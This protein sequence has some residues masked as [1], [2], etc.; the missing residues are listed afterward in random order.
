[1]T[2]E[3]KIKNKSGPWSKD[4]KQYISENALKQSPDEIAKKLRRNPNAVEKYM[5]SQGL[6]AESGKIPSKI[7]VEHDIKDTPHWTE[8]KK[9]FSKDELE[10]VVYHWNNTI[11]QF[12]NDIF[13]TEELQIIDMIK[14]QVMMDRL[15]IKEQE[16]K[17]N[18]EFL[19]KKEAEL[20]R[21]PAD[22]LT[23][24][25][26]DDLFETQRQLSSY[27]AAASS[28]NKEYLDNLKEKNKLMNELKA[29]RSQRIKE[30]QS[31][32][33]T[34]AAWIK[35]V[36]N[37]PQLMYKLGEDMEK[38]RIAMTV[39]MERL[40]EYHTYVDGDV[41][42]PLLTPETVFMVENESETKNEVEE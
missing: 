1:M 35:Q 23:E 34:M 25:D 11:R 14:L 18:I 29:T 31:G 21:I 19:N 3:P 40:A 7:V 26:K 20:K 9:Q 22:T 41:D 12:N 42:Q 28:I 39:E 6:I 30:I 16:I 2:T 37:N 4:E 8:L 24:E 32:K 5:L 38:M 27:Y 10:T 15:L 17:K 33:D 36:L 13:H